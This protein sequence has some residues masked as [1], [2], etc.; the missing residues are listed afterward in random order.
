MV[1]TTSYEEDTAICWE[2]HRRAGGKGVPGEGLVTY[3]G[4]DATPVVA[5]DSVRR[6][7]DEMM[8]A[9]AR[10]NRP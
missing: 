8:T 4:P 9:G 10:E 3:Q 6:V 1:P 2:A 7:L 5:V